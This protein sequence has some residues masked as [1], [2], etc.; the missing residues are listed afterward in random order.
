M[1]DNTN[2]D[3]DRDPKATDATLTVT[4]DDEEIVLPVRG[5]DYTINTTDV[6]DSAQ[7][8]GQFD[9]SFTSTEAVV[10]DY[11]DNPWD[12]HISAD[13]PDSE[14]DEGSE[15]E[16]E[17]T[18]AEAEI[19]EFVDSLDEED[20][21]MVGL[22]EGLPTKYVSELTNLITNTGSVDSARIHDNASG[23]SPQPATSGFGTFDSFDVEVEHDKANTLLKGIYQRIHA[24]NNDGYEVNQLVL[25]LPQ[26]KI[27]E[28][29]AQA[30]HFSS[31]EDVLPVDEVILVSG[32]MVHPV[33]DADAEFSEYLR[34]QESADE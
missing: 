26:Y 34:E 20:D 24:R 16:D 32:P 6:V 19:D 18:D 4:H 22:A 5:V 25:G 1:E 8:S 3:T 2:T 17:N 29:W 30:E 14:F 10:L 21:E 27:L 9:L 28:P 15:N 13:N 7:M 11:M 31:I 12:N 33:I 23:P